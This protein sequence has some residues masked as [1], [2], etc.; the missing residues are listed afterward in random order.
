MNT[1][2]RNAVFVDTAFFIA[3]LSRRDR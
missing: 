2:P 3:F 1:A